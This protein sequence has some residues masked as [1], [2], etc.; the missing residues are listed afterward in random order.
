MFRHFKWPDDDVLKRSK[1][2]TALNTDNCMG[3]VA[4]PL[5]ETLRYKP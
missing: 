1:H 4:A 2:V 3:H 5:V